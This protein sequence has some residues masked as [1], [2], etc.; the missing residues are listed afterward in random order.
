MSLTTILQVLQ[1]YWVSDPGFCIIATI[2]LIF[3]F[4]MLIDCLKHEPPTH[5]KGCWILVIL[6]LPVIGAIIYLIVN[7]LPKYTRNA[8]DLFPKSH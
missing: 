5:D 7:R 2:C 6:M 8:S 3:H 4:W 1:F